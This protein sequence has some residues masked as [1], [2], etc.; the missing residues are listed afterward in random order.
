MSY[1]SEVSIPATHDLHSLSH[2]IMIELNQTSSAEVQPLGSIAWN[3]DRKFI[4]VLYESVSNTVTLAG[5]PAV[6]ADT[7]TEY[8]IHTDVSQA[9]SAGAEEM[10]AGDAGMMLVANAAND[11]FYCWIQQK[12]YASGLMCE[13]GVTANDAMNVSTTDMWDTI[14]VVMSQ[15]SSAEYFCS[16]VALGDATDASAGGKST[17]DAMLRCD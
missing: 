15:D 14:N 2:P 5:Q 6:W 9:E 13:E 3:K 7:T 16:A 10:D 12:G 17:C 8:V 1:C 11:D 4:H